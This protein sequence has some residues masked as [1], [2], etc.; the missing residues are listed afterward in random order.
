MVVQNSSVVLV[1]R[2]T[3][4]ASPEMFVVSHFILVTEFA[5]LLGSAALE[6]KTTNGKLVESFQNNI[7]RK[8][9]METLKISIPAILYLLQN[10]LLYVALSNLSAPLFQVVYQCKLLTTALVSVVLLNRR[11]AAMQWLCLTT[12]G[13]GVAI[14]VLGEQQNK[15]GGGE[16]DASAVDAAMAQH[17]FKGMVSV[18]ISC[19]S[20][21]FAGVYFEKVL[22]KAPTKAVSGEAQE[23][24]MSMWMRNIQLAM[25]SLLIAVGQYVYQMKDEDPTGMEAKPFFYGFDVWVWIL[26]ALQ[27]GGGL[28]IA[29]VMKYADNVLKGLATGVAVAVSTLC[30]VILFG[31]PLTGQFCVGATVILTSVYWFSNGTPASGNTGP[32]KK[33]PILPTSKDQ[34]MKPIL[35]AV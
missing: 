28:L 27:A 17:M 20:S 33:G 21:A 22:K 35:Q 6:Y 12:L 7:L 14:V 15:E 16:S 29:A 1:G 32:A 3:R 13:L 10:S 19:F 11:Y 26:V 25:F 5:K 4:S 18:L 24:P 9:V 34:E 30:S 23:A 8:P 2:Y 31:T